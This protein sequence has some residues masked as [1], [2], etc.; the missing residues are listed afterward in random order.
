MR[1]R[2]RAFLPLRD[3]CLAERDSRDQREKQ[4]HFGPPVWHINGATP[5]ATSDLLVLSNSSWICC[6][7]KCSSCRNLTMP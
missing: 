7:A 2:T 5:L 4:S 6:R 3:R 1:H